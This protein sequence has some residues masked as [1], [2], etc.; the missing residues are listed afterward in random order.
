MNAKWISLLVVGLIGVTALFLSQDDGATP[1]HAD[2]Q[3]TKI[4]RETLIREVVATG[5]IRPVTGAEINVGSRVSGIVM[6]LP[7]KVG[8]TVEAGELLAQLDST[9]FEALVQQ[10]AADVDLSKAELALAESNLARKQN[11]A[12]QGY[13]PEA[14]L[15]T[16]IRDINVARAKVALNEARLRSAEIDFGYTRITAP[17][18]GVIADVTTREGET[19]AASFSAPKFVSIVDLD[20]LEVQAFVDETDIGR[21]FVG[22]SARFEVDTYSDRDFEARVTAIN[23][24]AALQNS[25][26]NYI[27][28]LEFEGKDGSIL[29]PE[30]TAHVRLQLE[31]R[32]NVLTAP[33]SALRRQNGRQI[34]L[35]ERD[36]DWTEQQVRIGWRTDQKVEI[37]DGVSE[38]DVVQLNPS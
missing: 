21:I 16:A 12:A 4:S 10:A 9:P 6:N 5:V 33:R 24:K 30:M 34:I 29:R 25:V 35:V 38:G 28:V 15:Q 22:Q 31:E 27:V 14:D 26:V 2:V 7:V 20:R 13:S 37:V 32:N 36:G 17:I 3:T 8:D 19:V 18:K 23:P 1:A 11:L